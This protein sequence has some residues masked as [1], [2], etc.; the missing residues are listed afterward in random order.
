MLQAMRNI[1]N[2]KSNNHKYLIFDKMLFNVIFKEIA[3]RNV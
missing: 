2:H 3:S 1:I